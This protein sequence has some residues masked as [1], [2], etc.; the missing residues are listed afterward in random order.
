[1]QGVTMLHADGVAPGGLKIHGPT[2]PADF[3]RSLQGLF[4][5]AFVADRGGEYFSSN[6][7]GVNAMSCK[8]IV[9]LRGACC[10][11]RKARQ[12]LDDWQC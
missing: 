12:L 2:Q 11:P 1:M 10:R 7:G 9:D 3:S 8:T 5:G 6:V 4:A